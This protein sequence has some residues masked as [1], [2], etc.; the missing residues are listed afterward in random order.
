MTVAEAMDRAIGT[1]NTATR[2]S[3]DSTGRSRQ[4]SPRASSFVSPSDPQKDV[5]HHRGGLP[6]RI[7]GFHVSA[8][9][10]RGLNEWR[11]A[12]V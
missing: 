9:M 3:R 1:R 5:L 11:Q 10:R 8:R 6:F 4:R 12:A 2:T 7:A